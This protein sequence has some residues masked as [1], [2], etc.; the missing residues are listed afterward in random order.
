MFTGEMSWMCVQLGNNNPRLLSIENRGGAAI[1]SKSV[2]TA[3]Y[4][5][6]E[7]IQISCPSYIH[8]RPRV[9]RGQTP[10]LPD[11]LKL[12]H[13]IKHTAVIRRRGFRSRLAFGCPG[14]WELQGKGCGLG[15]ESRYPP[16]ASQ[17]H[18]G[19][20]GACPGRC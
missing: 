11:S 8:V 4:V 16:P 5:F 17:V 3:L 20:A 14:L 18:W 13:P 6:T 1:E 10:S 7:F 15:G 9:L 2:L 12:L 19:L